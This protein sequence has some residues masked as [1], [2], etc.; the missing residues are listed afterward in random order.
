MQR[1]SATVGLSNIRS[2]VLNVTRHRSVR[3]LLPI[4]LCPLGCQWGTGTREEG[5]LWL[6]KDLLNSS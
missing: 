5:V 4:A 3:D 2:S 1:L 6:L